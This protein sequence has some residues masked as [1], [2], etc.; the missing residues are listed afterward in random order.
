MSA[1]R[2]ARVMQASLKC[3]DFLIMPA[4]AA[5]HTL[6]ATHGMPLVL[7]TRA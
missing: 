3:L 4:A 1:S 7:L 2:H 5:R 6:P